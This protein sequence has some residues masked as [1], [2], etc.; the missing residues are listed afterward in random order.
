MN[1]ILNLFEMFKNVV[2]ELKSFW[3]VHHEIISTCNTIGSYT[4]KDVN[5]RI[6]IGK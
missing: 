2:N 1:T 3:N 6:P 5:Y 4:F